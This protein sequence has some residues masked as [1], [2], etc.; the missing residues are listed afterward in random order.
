MPMV[1][2]F[3][4]SML[5]DAL[6]NDP[7]WRDWIHITGLDR[8]PWPAN[9]ERQGEQLIIRRAVNESGCIHFPYRVDQ[10]GDIYV[11]TANLMEREQ[12]YQLVVELAR[13]HINKLRNQLAIWEHKGLRVPEKLARDIHQAFLDFSRA[14]RAE[15]SVDANQAGLSALTTSLWAGEALTLNYSEQAM[16]VRRRRHGL[17][18]LL[19]CTFDDG[20][21]SRENPEPFPSLFDHVTIPIHWRTLEEV[22]GNPNWDIVGQRIAWC[23]KNKIPYSLGPLVD[24]RGSEIPAWLESWQSDQQLLVTFILDM[25]ETCISRFKEHVTTWETTARSNSAKMLG[26]NEEQML[27]LTAR[28]L[29]VASEVDPRARFVITLDQPWGE[30]VGRDDRSDSPFSFLDNL[31]RMDLPIAAINLEIAMGYVPGG[32]YCRNLLDFSQL[33]DHY[34]ELRL[35]LRCRLYF[36]SETAATPGRNGTKVAAGCWHGPANEEVHAEWYH[37]F[38]LT[39]LAK[40]YVEL[41][42]VGQFHDRPNAPW[43]RAGLVHAD[44]TDK[45][46]IERLRV[47]R[48]TFLD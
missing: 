18:G 43:P 30:Y 7:H 26:L 24:F 42:T 5:D 33:L 41:V 2:G 39:A 47:L 28:I 44:G 11:Q 20:L 14:A 19:G 9:V 35:P 3:H 16:E 45:P 15:N 10:F 12:P 21:L 31:Q 13:G 8:M 34:H 32:T 36:P 4:F 6:G 38:V 48:R 17:L 37:A 1:K 25:V 40:P 46:A 23:R 27:W 22:Q 29:E